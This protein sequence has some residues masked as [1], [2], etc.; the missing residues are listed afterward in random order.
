[1][2]R[3]VVPVIRDEFYK[4]L[5][6]VQNRRC[7]ENP[8]GNVVFPNRGFRVVVRCINETTFPNQNYHL[9]LNL[10]T[11]LYTTCSETVIYQFYMKCC[12]YMSKVFHYRFFLPSRERSRIERRHGL[13]PTSLF[14]QY[15]KK[16]L[17]R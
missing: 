15:S 3:F 8:Q 6:L 4:P 12:V 7:L 9:D 14:P 1:M 10:W 5:Q 13:N 17:H 11:R 16:H 2:V